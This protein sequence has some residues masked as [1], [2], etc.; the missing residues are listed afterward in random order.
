MRDWLPSLRSWFEYGER[1][2][3]QPTLY[4]AQTKPP[5]RPVLDTGLGFFRW[6]A[7]SSQAPCQARGDGFGE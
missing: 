5:R 4:R 2:K 7:N 6:L 3:P 1:I